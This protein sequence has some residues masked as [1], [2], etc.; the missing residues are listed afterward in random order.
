MIKKISAV[1]AAAACAGVMVTFV[2]GFAPEV[3]AS[4]PRQVD[5]SVTVVAPANKLAEV[6]APS[7]AQIRNAGAPSG[8]STS[9]DANIGCAQGWPFY[10]QSCLRDG[11][12]A[13][14]N[15][16]AV[17]VIVMDRSAAL[18]PRR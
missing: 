5:A 2:T 15:A 13:D 4:A 11:R 8:R 17:R 14:G 9:R 3:A 16:R 6:A 1:V 12:Q 18:K 7:G 10:E